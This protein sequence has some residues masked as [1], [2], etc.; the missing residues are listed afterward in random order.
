MTT[1][2]EYLK[3]VGEKIITGQQLSIE[4]EILTAFSSLVVG[5]SLIPYVISGGIAIYEFGKKNKWW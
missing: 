4:E 5:L 1:L 3:N 2:I